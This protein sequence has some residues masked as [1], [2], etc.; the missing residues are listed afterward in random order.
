M[1]SHPILIM[2][3][4]G[5]TNSQAD[6]FSRYNISNGAVTITPSGGRFG[7]GGM[8]TNNVI[9]VPMPT[10][11]TSLACGFALFMATPGD[12]TRA[13]I[14]IEPTAGTDH[15]YL[16]TDT[17]GHLTVY[18]HTGALL[19]TGPTLVPASAWVYVEFDCVISAVGQVNVWL[20]GN[21]EISTGG[22]IQNG[23]SAAINNLRWDGVTRTIQVSDWYVKNT[24]GNLG[25]SRVILLLPASDGAHLQWTPSTG[26][27]HF[28]LVNQVPPGGD[29]SYVEDTVASD[30]DC[31][32]FSQLP[33]IPAAITAVQVSF[34]ARTTD[35][36]ARTVRSLLRVAGVDETPMAAH[37]LSST[38]LD[39]ADIYVTNPQ[40]GNPWTGNDVNTSQYGVFL[41]S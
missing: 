8:Q 1:P 5:W 36:T 4:F 19:A 12:N 34:Y 40:S 35:A 33:Y 24:I 9:D 6:F 14:R 26:V 30:E 21:I 11:P 37:N 2:E 41:A 25:Q 38:F 20:N 13:I 3:S 15:W 27:T 29:V 23:A 28:N 31:Y 39:F 32:N 16:G 18:D 7:G 17:F 10:A 22:N